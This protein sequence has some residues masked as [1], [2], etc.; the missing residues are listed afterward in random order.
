MIRTYFDNNATT[1]IDPRVVEVMTRASTHDWGNPSSLHHSGRQA[2]RVLEEAR[3][4]IANHLAVR[5]SEIV[6][7]GSGTE[8]NN[9]ALRGLA[10][11]LEAKQEA[12][13]KTSRRVI[14][15]SP[16]EHP[17][18]L[19]VLADLK[20]SGFEIRELP[21]G[22]DGVVDIDRGRALI[23]ATVAFSVLMWA[24]NEVGTVQP[25][26]EWASIC[27]AA[28]VPLHVDAIQAVGKLGV[29]AIPDG[30]TTLSASAH[31]FFGPKGI[32]A[33]FVRSGTSLPSFLL[34][35]GQE[36]ERRAGT[37]N[38][39]GAV[40]MAKAL[41]LAADEH[42]ERHRH[43]VDLEERLAQ[44]S[45]RFGERVRLGASFTAERIPGTMTMVFPGRHGEALLMNLD[46]HGVAVSLGSACS[47]GSVNPSHVLAAMGVDIDENYSS[48]RVSMSV[49]NT[50]EDVD[51][52]LRAV[53][54]VL[55]ASCRRDERV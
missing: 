29:R 20:T 35:G 13:P 3:E 51:R 32:G 9:Q 26:H 27:R 8:A 40:G 39:V 23:D 19:E 49:R 28:D 55:N 16:I 45:R 33:L 1:P 24:N 38:V 37:E 22:R 10:R 12:K 48:V 7:S 52:F 36:R 15:T 25:I 53:D 5:A 11:R 6:F 31:K 44:G 4:T 47:S 50:V 30:V 41:D 42:V 2:R 43:L 18:V 46:L 21:V 14:L 54:L 17:S 34:G